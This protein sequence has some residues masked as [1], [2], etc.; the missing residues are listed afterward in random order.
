MHRP[1]DRSTRLDIAATLVLA[2]LLLTVSSCTL[3]NG[4]G[5]TSSTTPPAT[6]LIRVAPALVAVDRIH[7]VVEIPAGTNDKWEVDKGTGALHWERKNG[8]PRVVQYLAYP[9]NYGMIPHTAL[10]T[11]EG[12]DGDPLDVLL[13][14]PAIERGSVVTA[15]PVA[16]FRL[17]DDGER[18]DK[19]IAVPLEGPFSDVRTLADLDAHY[20]G[21]REIILT[22]FANYKGP[23]RIT[24]VGFEDVDRAVA[25]VR[26]ASAAFEGTGL[27][28]SE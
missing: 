17:L 22:W 26:Q 3:P 18:D 7:V 20:R 1:N 23:G 24:P 25:V 21:A 13:L 8:V 12:G 4:R 14:G 28:G 10:P 2:A 5:N 27:R 16:V 11:A 9:G 19:I 6:D 15:R